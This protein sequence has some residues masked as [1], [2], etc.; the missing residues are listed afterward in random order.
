MNAT[1]SRRALK[2]YETVGYEATIEFADQHALVGLLFRAMMESLSDSERYLLARQYQTKGKALGKAQE[3]LH[4]LRSTLDF[5]QGGELAKDLD[6]IYEYCLRLLVRAHVD[7]DVDKLRE[8]RELL[9]RLESAW[10][11]IPAKLATQAQ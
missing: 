11:L 8:A 9:G 10:A 3:I 6:A 1:Y 7:N 2:L 5:N 4:A